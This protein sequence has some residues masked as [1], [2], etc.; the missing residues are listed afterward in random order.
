M[1]VN[2]YQRVRTLVDD[3]RATEHRLMSQ[4]TGDMMSARDAGLSG[5]QLMPVLHRNRE[6]WGA[7]A[8]DC[9]ATGNS[10]PEALR[11]SIVSIGLWVDRFTT[12]VVT[13]RDSIDGLIDVNRSIIEGLT[14]RGSPAL[15]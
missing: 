11:A 2:A 9:G 4:I 13:G 15:S 7:F 3:P 1:S 8:S 5:S 12:D 6:V 10:L 14:V